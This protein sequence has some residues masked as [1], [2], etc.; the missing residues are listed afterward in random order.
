MILIS[1]SCRG[2][3]ARESVCKFFF[4]SI[5]NSRR[6]F[7]L[8][9]SPAISTTLVSTYSRFFDRVFCLSSSYRK[10]RSLRDC[11]KHLNPIVESKVSFRGRLI[12]MPLLSRVSKTLFHTGGPHNWHHGHAL[13]FFYIFTKVTYQDIHRKLFRIKPYVSV[14]GAHR[15]K[16]RRTL[17][18][19]AHVTCISLVDRI[20]DQ[21][22]KHIIYTY[23]VTINI[24]EH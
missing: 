3:K 10:R 12:E 23:Q 16:F 21:S 1:L 6:K 19:A 17:A 2:A 11:S 13:P 7:V 5:A 4:V 8:L 24:P 14:R 9:E 22:R 18:R 15:A 20:L